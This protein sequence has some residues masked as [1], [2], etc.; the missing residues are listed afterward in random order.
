MSRRVPAPDSVPALVTTSAELSDLCQRLSSETFVTVDTEFMRERTYWPE[1]CVVQ[2]A[3]EREVAVVDALAPD[4]D[5][6]PLGR[7]S[8]SSCCDSGPCR[9]RC[10]TRRSPPWWPASAT[11]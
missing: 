10:S 11:R 8:R 2:L 9:R 4:L 7:T 6:A 1:L 5:L 3:G